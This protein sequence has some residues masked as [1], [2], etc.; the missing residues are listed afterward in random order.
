MHDFEKMGVFYLGKELDSETKQL[1][2]NLVLMKSKDLTTHAMIIGMTGSGK[3]GLGIS[4]IEEAALDQIPVIA[5]D[6]KGDL[7]NL[8]LTFP[9]LRQAD[10]EPWINLSEASN[11]GLSKEEFA[12]NQAEQ[13]KKG[14]ASWGQSGE[15]IQKFKDAAQVK[16]YTPGSSA[17]LSVSLLKSFNPPPQ[18]ILEDHDAYRERLDVTATSILSLIGVNAQTLTSREHILI[19]NILDHAWQQHQALTL[20]D[21]II[22]IQTPPMKQVGVLDL[23]SFY[24]SKDRLTLAMQL[25]NVLASPSFKSWLEGEAL[26]IQHFLYNSS[27]KPCVSVFSIAHLSDSERMFFVTMLLNEVISWMRSQ[28]GTGSLRAM[29]YMDELFGFLPPV[30]NPPSKTPLLTLLKQARAYGLGL[31]LSTQNPVDLDYKAL[32][33]T[34]TWLIGRLQTQRD[35]ERLIAGL[36]GLASD[37]PFNRTETERLIAGLSQRQFYLHSVHEANPTLFSTRW[38]LSYLAGPMTRD[39]IASLNQ[40][41]TTPQHAFQPQKTTQ[42]SSQPLLSA[43]IPQ[44]YC[45]PQQYSTSSLTY[46]PYCIGVGDVFYQSA[47]HNVSLNQNVVFLAPIHDGVIS[48]DWSEAQKV[49]LSL[50]DISRQKPD[51]AVFEAYP[52]AASNL[53]NYDLWE[54]SLNQFIR[55]NVSLKLFYSPKLKLLSQVNEDQRDFVIRLQH[56]A[57]EA[58]DEAIEAL[59]KKYATRMNT[60]EDR[61]RRAQQAVEKQSTLANQKKMDAMV[62]TGT[63]I[64]SALFGSKKISATSITR[65]GSAMKSSSKALKSGQGIEQAQETLESVQNQL[66]ELSQELENHVLKISD[67]YD[68]TT[69]YLEEVEIR[70]T[71]N[72]IS[73]PLVAL[74]WVPKE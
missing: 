47:K 28:P 34:G 64:F 30:A 40:I 6:P 43:Q 5:I 10:F 60:L 39:Q 37:K 15:R 68:V 23:E 70:A 50:K 1:S 18:V 49:N 16:V 8:A 27:G 19:S 14:L 53:K 9:Q 4:M 48:V 35:I 45:P 17:G 55:T 13:W 3:T 22:M 56:A 12:L 58:R 41:S 61:L 59:K 20:S 7:A 21:L 63:A 25:N 66:Q 33:N 52:Q 29:L 11:K 65:V 38:V 24:P 42:S 74:A 62:S 67:D 71:S 2:D 51:N 72:N 57:H 26:D 46:E 32:S 69:D 31:V 54:K 73:I 44:V 36:E